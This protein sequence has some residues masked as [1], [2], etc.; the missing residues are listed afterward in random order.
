[1][2]HEQTSYRLPQTLSPELYDITLD[3]SPRRPK[4]EGSVV[5]HAMLTRAT[6]S[7]ELNARGLEIL[8]ASLHSGR[9]SVPLTATVQTA[10]EVILLHAPSRMPKGAVK[11]SIRFKGVLSRSMHGLYLA[12]DGPE[13]ALVTQCE[14]ADAR[15]IFPCV[16]EPSFKARLKWTLVTCPDMTVITNGVLNKTETVGRGKNKQIR[17]LFH[18]TSKVSTYL[19]AV[20][21]GAFDLSTSFLVN[22]TPCRIVSGRNK[23]DQTT[24][25]QEVTEYVLPWYEDYF[26][27]PY[28]Y[29]KLDQVAVPGFDAGAMENIGAIF[30][31]QNLL[32]MREGSTSLSAQ[33]RI[34]EVIAHEIAHQWFGNLVTMKWW[35]DLWLNEAFA[36]WIAFKTVA[37]WRPEWR[38]WEDYLS[39][40]EAAL[41]ADAKAS[42]H[43]IYQSVESPGQ[44]TE[45]FDVITYEKG[46]AVLRM[47]ERAIG[48]EPFRAGIRAYVKKFKHAN[49][50]GRDLWQTLSRHTKIPVQQFIEAWVTQSGFPKVQVARVTQNARTYLEVTQS[51]FSTSGARAKD[52]T[53]WPIPL[54]VSYQTSRGM[55]RV[56]GMIQGKVGRIELPHAEGEFILWAFPN[57]D[58]ASFCRVLLDGQN[59]KEILSSGLEHLGAASKLTLVNDLWAF[60]KSGDGKL[61]SVLDTL[62]ALRGERDPII[63][64][65]MAGVLGEISAELVAGPDEKKFAHFVEHL[66]SRARVHFGSHRIPN[67]SP[68]KSVGRAYCMRLAGGLGRVESVRKEA[69]RRLR[70]EQRAPEAFDPNLAGTL[71]S[72]AA[73]GGDLK[74]FKEFCAIYFARKK[75]GMTPSL[76]AR[77]LEGMMS[78]EAPAAN[79]LLLRMCREGA[80]PQEQL[81]TVLT[82]LVARRKQSAR[83]W[84]FLQKHW[85]DLAPKVGGMGI[86]RLV[87]SLGLLPQEDKASVIAFFKAHPMPEAERAQKKALES[88]ATRAKLSKRA[89]PEL[90]RW[91]SKFE[92]SEA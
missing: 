63:W 38:M 67:E 16:D 69:A 75:S 82:S 17:H 29:G 44:A 1:M 61:K 71:V 85:T 68:D 7:L 87:E 28:H 41:E 23:L 32:L 83:A 9:A 45:L 6:A 22:K 40:K 90:V 81:R 54:E 72:L 26:G 77:Y 52:D 92:P 91:L 8:E 58:G 74:R 53:L 24:F 25:A 20:T 50:A 47:T 12:E 15:A 13:K 19:A 59:L 11:I 3:A 39:H 55:H 10:R 42:T 37:L 70:E 78:F 31:R 56:R 62:W 84:P 27:E 43:P 18:P 89:T 5:I 88:F 64:G 76:Q 80:I 51:R 73:R 33:K 35:D 14:A 46:C 30:Y 34:A 48:A 65:A 57:T 60:V 66:T 2:A 49:A 36:T 86:S 21:V 4:F 79:D